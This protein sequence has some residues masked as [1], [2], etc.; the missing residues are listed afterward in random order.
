MPLIGTAG[1]VDHGKSTLIQALTGR[2][3][4]RWDEEKRRG[5]TIDLGFAWADL[6]D[7]HEVSFV[8]VPGHEKYLKNM[9]A[10]I[11]AIDIALFV[12]AADEGWM[13]QSEEHL[14]VLD[15]LGVG[16][17]VVALTK[18]DLVDD[19]MIEL[20]SLEI[21][22]KLIGTTLEHARVVPVSATTGANIDDLRSE[23][24]RLGDGVDP[25]GKGSARMWIDRSFSVPGTGTVVTGTLLEGPIALTDPLEVYPTGDLAKVRSLQ[26]HEKDTQSAQPGTRVAVGLVGLAREQAHRGQMLGSPGDWRSTQRFSATLKHARYAP[27]LTEKGAY[28]LHVGSGGHNVRIQKIDGGFVVMTTEEPLPLRMGDRFILRDS[29]RRLVVAGGRIL[30][31]APG[32][33]IQALTEA[34][35][36]DPDA[37]PDERARL[38]LELRGH[39]LLDSLRQDSGGGRPVNAVQIG[40]TAMTPAFIN[41]LVAIAEETT[42]EEHHRH[43]LRP[44][45]PMATLATSLGLSKDVVEEVVN[46]SDA[47]RVDGPD[48]SLLSHRVVLDVDSTQLWQSARSRLAAGID[49][50][51]TSELGLPNELLHLLLRQH[52]LV[53]VSDN[54]VYLP[55]QMELIVERVK[56]LESPFSVGDAKENLGLSRKYIVPILE[57]LDANGVT[58]RRGENRLLRD[59]GQNS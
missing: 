6:G 22:E 35:L 41:N 53:R 47:L 18:V 29:G 17:G 39:D 16:R 32:S 30:D 25:P 42:A 5:L 38:L 45:L 58:V 8:D 52:E 59:P 13:P 14:A 23:L 37:D 20:A 4:D 40:E 3:P 46:R 19:D 34:P 43:P 57:W 7:G 48:V 24:R 26:R 2:D 28:H 15:L 56:S 49:V 21:H 44:G 10:G 1:H 36:I 51:T 33:S 50:P 11:E 31:P 27:E 9:L 12:V 54:L 55:E